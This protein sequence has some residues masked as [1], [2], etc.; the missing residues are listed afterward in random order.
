MAGADDARQELSSTRSESNLGHGG[1][2]IHLSAISPLYF[3]Q[4]Q[5]NPETDDGDDREQSSTPTQS[6]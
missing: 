1:G 6:P 5:L 3:Q 2:W 4:G